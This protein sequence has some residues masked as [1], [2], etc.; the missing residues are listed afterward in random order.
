M[1]F[2]SIH[3]LLTEGDGYYNL[4]KQQSTNSGGGNGGVVVNSEGYSY[5]NDVPAIQ[6]HHRHPGQK[7]SSSSHRDHQQQNRTRR[8]QRRVTH[9]EK[10]YHSGQRKK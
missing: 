10:R 8:T 3:A 9:N 5:V 2:L 1:N 7:S 6:S 4:Q